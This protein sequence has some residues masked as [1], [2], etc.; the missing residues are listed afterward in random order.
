M[1]LLIVDTYY[2]EFIN[3]FWRK[4]PG[5]E[6]QPYNKQLGAL[7][8][9]CFGTSDFYSYNLTQL[10]HKAWD[11]IA[12]DET[13]QKRWADEHALQISKGA[14]DRLQMLPFLY[15][16]IGRPGWVQTI[17]LEQIKFYK[18]DILYMQDLSILSPATLRKAK[19][20]VKLVV[21]QIASSL[22][23]RKNIMAFDLIITSFPHYVKTFRKMGV[24]SEYLKI[25]FE[26]RILRKI[27]K[28]RKE[29]DVTFVGSFTPQHR[30]GTKTLELVSK[31]IPIHVWGRGTEFL[32]PT[33]S[34]QK[35]YHGATW[36][37]DMYKILA[38]SKIVINRHINVAK[39]YANN[40]RLYETTGMGAMLM[41]DSKKNLNDLF[42]VGKEVVVYNSPEDLLRKIEY[43]LTHDEE[44]KKITKAGQKRTLREHIYKRRMKELAN[45]LQ[46]YI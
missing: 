11:T 43:Y 45:I 2:N 25:A 10:G 39:N 27:K 32:S 44:R 41:T 38:R 1:K 14:L 31:K 18:P 5:L 46:K 19:K 33:S 6:E 22:P 4:N 13:L 9:Q 21:G 42:E 24:P 29:Y 8:G 16:F 26:P 20:N 37:L 40:M 12:N 3:N 35:N 23:P 30:A 28:Q 34:L 7:L 15:R 36:G 17:V